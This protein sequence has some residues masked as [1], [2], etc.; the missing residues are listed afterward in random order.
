MK[1]DHSKQS[2]LVGTCNIAPS[3]SDVRHI[4]FLPNQFKKACRLGMASSWMPQRTEVH[5]V[6]AIILF[7]NG[8]ENFASL[9]ITKQYVNNNNNNNDNKYTEKNICVSNLNPF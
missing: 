1:P 9:K 6:L 3:P 7:K 5:L 8:Q 4:A 2:T